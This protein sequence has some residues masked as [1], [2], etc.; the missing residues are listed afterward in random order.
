M[1]MKIVINSEYGG[2]G[3]SPESLHEYK[4]R[5]DINIDD[6]WIWEIPRNCP[7]LVEMVE[8]GGTDVNDRYSYL[9]VVEI[10]DDVEWE[11]CEYDGLEWIAEK[12]RTWS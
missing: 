12:H 10:P 5:A 9:K 8:E 2:F 7:H 3:L 4:K 11:I 6:F 1:K